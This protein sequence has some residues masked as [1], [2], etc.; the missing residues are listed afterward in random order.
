MIDNKPIKVF[1]N[2]D[3]VRDFTYIDDIVES[4]SCALDTPAKPNEHWNAMSPDP[5]TS[6]APY[7][8]Y[9]IG[10]SKPV[11]LMDYIYAIEK[12]LGRK[13]KLDKMPMQAG[14]VYSTYAD[15]DRLEYD[16]GY[17]PKITLE[18]G[19]DQFVCWYQEFY[20]RAKNNIKKVMPFE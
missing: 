16:L 17:R 4:V 13:A 11:P 5:A 7:R 6:N 9:N 12:S 10:N 3:M 20:S 2:G 19:V 18:K 15:V 14:D 8:I 1:N